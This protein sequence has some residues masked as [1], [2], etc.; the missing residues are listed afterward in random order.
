[1]SRAPAR[2]HRRFAMI[3][4]LLLPLSAQ[5]ARLA[6]IGEG[7]PAAVIPAVQALEQ[8]A[9][10]AGW[11]L[12]ESPAEA[13]RVLRV[14]V[15]VTGRTD[16]QAHRRFETLTTATLRVRAFDAEGEPLGAGLHRSLR[17]TAL[18][19][20]AEIDKALDEGVDALVAPR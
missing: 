9:E 19:A 13:D 1:M 14:A 11:T 3:A 12:T 17:Y 2:P 18:T 5:A 10:S 16:L 4:V 6:V 7:D 15:D 8:R 20:D